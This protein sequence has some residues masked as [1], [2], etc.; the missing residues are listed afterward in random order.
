MTR[1]ARRT[2]RAALV[3]MTTAALLGGMLALAP[4]A[5]AGST[6]P[7]LPKEA[8]HMV[9]G[10]MPYWTPDAS[11]ASF[12]AN[13]DVFSD[14]AGF[15]HSATGA[16]T[17]T[18]QLADSSRAAIVQA[19]HAKGVLMI[20]AVTDGTPAHTMAGILANPTSRAAHVKALVD[21][22]RG[23]R[24]RRHRPG[25][26]EVRLLRRLVDV[27]HHPAELGRLRQAAVRRAA[28]QGAHPD[29][30]GARDVRQRP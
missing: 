1:T 13:A 12:E 3:S 21:A 14:I 10:W 15:W 7:I 27:G 16:S 2:T 24:L 18:D 30:L 11:L 28:R 5:D 8:R 19:V 29:R 20:G 4:A 17:I 23:Q 6:N 26:R 25:L 9:S 22:R